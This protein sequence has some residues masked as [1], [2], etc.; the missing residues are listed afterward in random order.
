MRLKLLQ[1]NWN[2]LGKEDPLFAVLTYKDKRGGK[3]DEREFFE[4][5]KK[6][7]KEVIDYLKS[8]K[9][10]LVY[11]RALD[12]GCGVGRLT[13]PLADYFSE[14]HGADIAPSMITLAK[15][16]NRCP[17]KCFY[18]LN[19][20]DNLSLFPNNQFDFVISKITL[21]HMEPQ[22]AKNYIKEFLRVLRPGGVA[23][24]Q[25]PE[26]PTTPTQNSNSLKQR[27]KNLI[28]EPV[29]AFYRHLTPGSRPLIEMYGITREEIKTLVWESGGEII[30][31]K[32]DK[33][34]EK[35]MSYQ[36]TVNKNS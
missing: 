24:F 21:Q 28:P 29:L 34:A 9:I 22:Y 3:W 15:G 7:V 30:A 33:S 5:G 17:G 25:I 27:I 20:Q 19:D 26:R 14:I 1:K 2:K 35:W 23:V 4:T 11:G 12:F 10:K 36:Y 6:E 18:H 13:T 31:I 16:R 8:L 32:E